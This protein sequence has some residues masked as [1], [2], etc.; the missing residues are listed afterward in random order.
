MQKRH[1]REVGQRALRRIVQILGQLD[2][3]HALDAATVIPSSRARSAAKRSGRPKTMAPTVASVA[4][5]EGAGLSRRTESRR[6]SYRRLK[7]DAIGRGL[8]LALLGFA[9]TTPPRRRSWR[10]SRGSP[11]PSMAS[12]LGPN[13]E[14]GEMP[15]H[16]YLSRRT[17]TGQVFP[18][19]SSEGDARSR[20]LPWANK[21][22]PATPMGVSVRG[23]WHS[24]EV[25]GRA[26]PDT[27][28]RVRLLRRELSAHV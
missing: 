4:L 19:S 21:G 22:A 13:P 24:V 8:A 20:R 9:E 2:A 14:V 17:F 23:R 7:H 28:P 25:F 26:S 16:I 12:S 1:V 11:V 18:V 15:V 5:K 27:F 3:D 6:P 10:A